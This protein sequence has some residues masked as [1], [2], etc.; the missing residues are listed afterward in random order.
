MA[1]TPHWRAFEAV[2]NSRNRVE[3]NHRN[4]RRY[5]MKLNPRRRILAVV[6][7]ALVAG[8]VTPCALHAQSTASTSSSTSTTKA[9]K[10]SKKA[11]KATTS[12]ATTAVSTAASSTS[13]ATKSTAKATKKGAKSTQAAATGTSTAPTPATA[14][15]SSSTSAKAPAAK[16]TTTAQAKTPPQPGMVWVNTSSKAYHKSGSKWYGNTKQ[17]Q[18]MTEAD[19][20]K[21]GYHAAKD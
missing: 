8:F 1:F 9:T 10:K 12:G 4:A 20:Q 6:L 18:W 7:T 15:A 5:P 14:S 13:G 21:A 16:T 17:G 3:A 2:Q 11:A 19:A